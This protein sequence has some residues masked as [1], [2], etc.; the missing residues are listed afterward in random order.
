MWLM[1][2]ESTL[3][4]NQSYL[5]ELAVARPLA[6][7]KLSHADQGSTHGGQ[8]WFGLTLDEGGLAD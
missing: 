7:I 3:D 4:H 2:K 8:K 1:W 5:A 6:I